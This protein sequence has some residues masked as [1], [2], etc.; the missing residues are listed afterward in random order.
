MAEITKANSMIAEAEHLLW[1]ARRPA[2]RVAILYPRSSE[3]WDQFHF[4][5]YDQSGTRLCMCCCVSSMLSHYIDYS[6]EAYALYVALATD[7]NIPV[8]FLDEDALEEAGTLSQYKLIFVT[9]PNVPAAGSAGLVDWV[10]HGGTLVTVAG[11]GISNAYDEP[12]D[13]LSDLA[14]VRDAPRDRLVLMS[15]ETINPFAPRSTPYV[16]NATGA[17]VLTEGSPALRFT[18]QA[19]TKLTSTG[20]V[21]KPEELGKFADGTPA[22]TCK[23]AGDGRIVHFAWLPGL[24]ESMSYH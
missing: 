6:G 4:N 20:S 2:S 7:S 5:K 17:C 15:D 13:E 24:S 11:A 9:E 3:L 14:G 10:K 8:D 1:T 23:A 19:V 16:P 18:A 12:S 22:I 21:P